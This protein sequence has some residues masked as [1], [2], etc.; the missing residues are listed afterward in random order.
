MQTASQ[1]LGIIGIITSI[2]IY[3]ARKRSTILLC[4][5]TGDIIWAAHY[6]LIGAWSGAGLCFLGMARE[7]VFYN[8]EKKW[9][10][11]RLWL[12]L[13]VGLT[14][15]SGIL[16]WEGPT[17]L[18]PVVGSVCAVISFW[19]TK[20]MHIRLLAVP[21]QGLWTIYNI[22]HRSVPGGISNGLQLVSVFIGLS[23]DLYERKKQKKQ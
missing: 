15:F 21:A 20:P 12:Y 23:R 2:F 5:F 22:I 14:M 1:V 11:S 16:T 4:K 19:C 9:A 8:K 10:S 17:S 6:F 3:I 7:I 18:L 13:F